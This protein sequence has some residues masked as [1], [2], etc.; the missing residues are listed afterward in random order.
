MAKWN[1]DA[2]GNPMTAPVQVKPTVPDWLA[3]FQSTANHGVS[4]PVTPYLT[5]TAISV[6]G[7]S[8]G[9][10]NGTAYLKMASGGYTGAG[11]KWEEA[12]IV[13]RGEYVFPKSDVSQSSGMPKP[14]AL[15]RMLNGS[16]KAPS[17]RG[18]YAE[19][20]FVNG[21]GGSTG[22]VIAHLSVEDRALL[23]LIA[24][25]VGIT[26]TQ[27]TMTNLVNSGNVNSSNRRQG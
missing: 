10:G 26:I 5:K 18:G 24:D 17:R 23:A 2:Q 21:G 8:A 20:G 9:G 27:D 11:G 7:G 19:G 6:S 3:R 16:T 14:D 12:G 15:L 1:R 4:L 22:Q 13:H 25:R